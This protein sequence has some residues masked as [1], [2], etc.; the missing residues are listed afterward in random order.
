M[1]LGATP[2]VSW[3]CAPAR[4]SGARLTLGTFATMEQAARAYG[5]AAW[6]LGR[7]HQ[8]LNYKDCT[9]LEEA[10]FLAGFDNLVTAEQRLRRQQLQRRL[11]I[12]E[13]DERTMEAWAATFPQDVLDE[14]AFYAQKKAERRANK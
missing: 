9:S 10:E 1:A 8:Q 11:A 2:P 5:A 14:H 12:A 4:T 13:T 7:H 6:R 3:V